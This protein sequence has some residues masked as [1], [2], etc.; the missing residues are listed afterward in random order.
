MRPYRIPSHRLHEIVQ[1]TK[2]LQPGES[3]EFETKGTRGL[4]LDAQLDLCDG[5][6]VGLPASASPAPA[7]AALVT[8][9]SAC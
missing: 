5:E 3:T 4:K 9:L 2:C 8:L 6:F 7:C 1:A